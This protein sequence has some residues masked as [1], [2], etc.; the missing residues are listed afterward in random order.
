MTTPGN[1]R[2][3]SYSG[4]QTNCVEV[5]RVAGGSAVRDTKNRGAGHIAVA[6]AQWANFLRSLKS[7]VFDR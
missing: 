4:Y 1:W 7:G 5:G 2:K 3:S 6:S